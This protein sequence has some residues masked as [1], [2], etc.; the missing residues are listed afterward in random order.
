M[1]GV[2]LYALDD[3]LCPAHR[4]F[5]VAPYVDVD[6]QGFELIS[7]V[8][9]PE[10]RVKYKGGLFEVFGYVERGKLDWHLVFA[11]VCDF[12]LFF[13]RCLIFPNGHHGE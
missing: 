11:L 6:F 10:E 2:I 9:C 7:V 5:V 13:F 1:R 12:K 4:P 8:R 3:L